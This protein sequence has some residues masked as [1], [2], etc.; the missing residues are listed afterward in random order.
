MVVTSYGSLPLGGEA[1]AASKPSWI[2]GRGVRRVL[3]GGALLGAASMGIVAMASSKS[4][5]DHS[6]EL[7]EI[8]RGPFLWSGT[9]EVPERN[10]FENFNYE[11]PAWK[12]ANEPD[13]TSL[14]CFSS[15]D[16][17]SFSP[18]SQLT[19]SSQPVAS[20]ALGRQA[21]VRILVPDFY[22]HPPLLAQGDA[23]DCLVQQGRDHR[24]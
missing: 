9:A 22:L 21:S 11:A 3:L 1:P 24:C 20:L 10:V 12:Q 8:V 2:A 23:V 19:V 5:N 15:P 7:F 4:P 18:A 13:A 14:S 16:F 17:E 6:T